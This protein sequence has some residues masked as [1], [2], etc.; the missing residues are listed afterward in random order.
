[1]YSF[2]IINLSIQKQNFCYKRLS[3]ILIGGHYYKVEI[4]PDFSLTKEVFTPT[5]IVSSRAKPNTD[6][7][8]PLTKYGNK[9]R[10]IK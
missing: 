10:N 9:M 8:Y 2:S 7:S 1:M 6:N 3:V 5:P 4:F